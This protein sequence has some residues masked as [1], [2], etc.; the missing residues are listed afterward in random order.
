MDKPEVVESRQSSLAPRIS[1]KR[2]GSPLARY[3]DF[4]A[5]LL[6][7]AA[8]AP[9]TWLSPRALYSVSHPGLFDDHWVID[10]SF[11]ASRGV[12]F[13]RDVAF[14]YGP[15]FQ[16]LFSAPAR[17]AGLSMGSIYAT[18]NTLPLWCTFLFGYL[19]LR[20]LLPEQ[21]AWKRFVLLL[22]L[23]FY[24]TPWDG[25]TAFAVFL[26]A[27][28]LRG[29]YAMQDGRRSPVGLGSGAALLCATAFLY[30]ADTGVYAVAA[31]LLSFGGV[32][33]E[34]RRQSHLY[35]RSAYALLGFSVVGGAL[36]FAINSAMAD[37]LDFRFWKSSLAIVGV[38][39]W[40]EPA[41]MSQA[42]MVYLL[43]TLLA[44][45]VVIALRR[46]APAPPDNSLT[47]RTGFLLG[48]FAL[49]ALTMQ[50]GLVRSDVNH[51]A[52]AVFAMV[53]FSGAVL[54]SFRSRIASVL[55]LVVAVTCSMLF[56]ERAPQRT[57][58]FRWSSILY[59]Y[60]QVLHPWT[61]CPGSLQEF[62][63]ACY[64]ADF[65]QL[66]GTV[67]GYLKLHSQ[68]NDSVVI[69]PYQYMFGMSSGRNVASGVEQSFLAAG[70]YLSQLAIA[71][72]EQG[73]AP[74][75]LYF[76]DGPL[77]QAIDGVPNF[78]RTPALWFWLC[79]HYRS[80]QE[81]APGVLGLQV[82]QARA[83]R[84]SLAEQP[85]L[86]SNQSYAVHERRSVFELGE[87]VWPSRADFL[88]LRMT[89]HYGVLW[90]LRKPERLQL[91]ITFADGSRA[92]KPFVI[93]PNLSSEVWFYPW[94]EADLAGY[95]RADEGQWRMGPRPAI[96]QLRLWVMPLDPISQQPDL[97]VVESVDAVTVSLAH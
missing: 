26:F 12:W 67:D 84:F 97:V 59:R 55:A 17:W 6:L 62:D 70:P 50:S 9:L 83:T 41:P 47:A 85:L 40:N 86:V 60:S 76:P 19:T 5:V 37:P 22:L 30:S 52:Y 35:R 96:T 90:K 18:Y 33:W 15:L 7:M 13:G 36:V 64:P 79:R 61:E 14:P 94:Q 75:G 71:G 27:W 77:S 58:V 38:H 42:G 63:Q 53:F 23:S 57:P 21:P 34:G 74:A 81:L 46:A 48:A 93:E 66:L 92:L 32:A 54:F 69:F 87:P 39:R 8:A 49:A 73:S 43:T 29:W 95:F 91:E 31:W 56:A 72:M 24:W 82:D 3:W 4:L 68:A 44:A 80:E 51:I 10:T 65:T 20:L 28:F 25:R 2:L 78:T 45:A 16:W 1:G 11:K 89:V 88:R